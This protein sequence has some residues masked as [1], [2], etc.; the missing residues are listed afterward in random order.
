[1]ENLKIRIE[2]D[3]ELNCECSED[4]YEKLWNDWRYFR[5]AV[6]KNISERLLFN[7]IKTDSEM[8]CIN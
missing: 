4:N 6:E 8:N 1:M 7:T 3:I 2:I 5:R